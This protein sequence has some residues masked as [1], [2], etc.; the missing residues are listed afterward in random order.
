MSAFNPSV[1]LGK[2]D[3]QLT[4]QIL[5]L[6]YLACGIGVPGVF[7]R[8]VKIE[9]RAVKNMVRLSGPPQAQLA[10]ISGSLMIPRWLP[11]ESKT[12][13]PSEPVQ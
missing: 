7:M 8:I 10:G 9:W 1:I 2:I 5:H 13:T 3:Q 12:Q 11:W 4:T 6:A